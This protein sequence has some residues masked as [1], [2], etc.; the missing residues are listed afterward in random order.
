MATDEIDRIRRAAAERRRLAEERDARIDE[1][2]GAVAAL[3]RDEFEE[4]V[5]RLLDILETIPTREAIAQVVATAISA[6]TTAPEPATTVVPA[7]LVTR[8][9]FTDKAE[10]F[11]RAHPEGT[12]T[13]QVSDAIGQERAGAHVSLSQVAK[14]RKS[15]AKRGM[16]MWYPIESAPPEEVTAT[17]RDWI[18]LVLEERSPLGS[19]DIFHAVQRVVPDAKKPSVVGEIHRMLGDGLIVVAGAGARGQLYRLA[20]P[21]EAAPTVQ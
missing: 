14:T 3:R 6:P 17:H 18:R 19:G 2:I 9:T 1:A 16:G 8:V 5:A 21:K 13:A 10:A 15:I 4:A 11:V 12:T 20:D 7:S